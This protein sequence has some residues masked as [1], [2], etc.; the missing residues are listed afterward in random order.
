MP[1]GLTGFH[2]HSSFKSQSC[3]REIGRDEVPFTLEEAGTD[4]KSCSFSSKSHDPMVDHN[5]G[6]SYQIMSQPS[7]PKYNVS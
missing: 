1:D 3:F 7:Q 2:G 4:T 5:L 6:F